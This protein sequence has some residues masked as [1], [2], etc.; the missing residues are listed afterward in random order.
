MFA[1]LRNRKKPVSQDINKGKEKVLDDV[2]RRSKQQR[3]E[4]GDHSGQHRE[5]SDLMADAR[6]HAHTA[7][8]A[9]T[10]PIYR[11]GTS[12]SALPPEMPLEI[13]EQIHTRCL[14][15]SIFLVE[16][17]SKEDYVRMMG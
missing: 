8:P 1:N 10:I 17:F 13:L 9:Q 2:P 12:S 5:V 16:T 3:S 15:H 7:M 11:H 4:A 14:A 6:R